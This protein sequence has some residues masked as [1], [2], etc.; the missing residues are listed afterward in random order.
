MLRLYKAIAFLLFVV[1]IALLAGCITSTPALPTIYTLT[2]EVKG[3][4]EVSPREGSHKVEESSVVSLKAEPSDG[5]RFNRW[6]GE[7]AELSN[8]STIVSIDEDK[9]VVAVFERMDYPLTIEIIGEGHIETEVVEKLQEEQHPYETIVKLTAI[10]ITGWAFSRWE[11]DLEDGEN[12]ME[13]EIDEDKH[14]VAVFEREPPGN[15]EGMVYLD[16]WNVGLADVTVVDKASG[17]RTTTNSEGYYRLNKVPAGEREIVAE[18]L[19]NES[20][21]KIEIPSDETIVRDIRVFFD[22]V[23]LDYFD[24]LVQ[25]I[26]GFPDGIRRW[27][28]GKDVAV[29]FEEESVPEGYSPQYK[30]TAWR[31]ISEWPK[32][33]GEEQLAVHMVNSRQNADVTVDWIPPGGLGPGIAGQCTYSWD[34]NWKI[35]RA[36]I[37]LDVQYEGDLLQ[38]L[39]LHE[40]GHS[41]RFG[42][43]PFY[44]DIM[45]PYLQEDVSSPSAREVE[46]ARIL[47]SIPTK[48]RL[49]D[50][51]KQTNTEKMRVHGGAGTKTETTVY[52]VHDRT[53]YSAL[54]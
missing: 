51:L 11:G 8:P 27:P 32:H 41:L 52:I 13:I 25:Q 26:S 42:H 44:G 21:V 10:P 50:W 46:A 22:M 45:W 15:V 17:I 23:T 7:V 48:I 36:E 43:S 18:A 30:E 54:R 33:I 34:F 2:I 39:A 14:V 1:S 6:E 31:S 47:Y 5:W 3:E 24:Q 19:Y 38:G 37:E 35:T 20:F 28:I 16:W 12:P 4:G 53:L 40:F 9:H 29:Y 49:V